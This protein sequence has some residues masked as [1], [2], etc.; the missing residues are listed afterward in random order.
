M[1]TKDTILQELASEQ[2]K[3]V[4]LE[5]TV[6]EARGKMESLRLELVGAEPVGEQWV[7]YDQ[8]ALRHFEDAL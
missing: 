3:L 5:R 2:A 4:A 7:E 8:E 1:R 6:E